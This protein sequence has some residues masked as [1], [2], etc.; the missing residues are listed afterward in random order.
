MLVP[1]AVGVY[2]PPITRKIG[3]NNSFEVKEQCPVVAITI[4]GPSS[5]RKKPAGEL[6]GAGVLHA[7]GSPYAAQASFED[8]L[9]QHQEDQRK[10]KIGH[11]I[12]AIDISDS[13]G[14]PSGLP[15]GSSKL[16]HI[17]AT[18]KILHEYGIPADT[19]LTLI[20]YDE[21]TD[22]PVQYE[23]DLG[24]FFQAIKNL[25]KRGSTNIFQALEVAKMRFIYHE[26]NT[27]DPDRKFFMLVTDGQ[28]NSGGKNSLDIYDEADHLANL[29]CGVFS[30]GVGEL[31]EESLIHGVAS[32]A[33][34]GG[35]CHTPEDKSGANVFAL[36]IPAFL[37]QMQTMDFYLKILASGFSGDQGNIR[38]F[39][40]NNNVKRAIYR[41]SDKH[42]N[43][44]H[45]LVREGYLREGYSIGFAPL[46]AI[47]SGR[48]KL[49]LS[50]QKNVNGDL[51]FPIKDIDIIPIEDL[52][53]RGLFEAGEEAKR[54]LRQIQNAPLVWERFLCEHLR[55]PNAFH[56]FNERNPGFVDPNESVIVERN[57]RDSQ[58][59]RGDESLS[60]SS[61]SNIGTR[62]TNDT[63]CDFRPERAGTVS[64]ADHGRPRKPPQRGA[65]DGHSGPLHTNLDASEGG[66][67][68]SKKPTP[69]D[70]VDLSQVQS[71]G[72]QSFNPMHSGVFLGPLSANPID[73]DSHNNVPP[74]KAPNPTGYGEAVPLFGNASIDGSIDVPGAKNLG[75]IAY[76]SDGKF[77]IEIL[78]GGKKINIPQGALDKANITLG[79][80]PD[81]EIVIGV[82]AISRVH[83]TINRSMI[84]LSIIDRGST[85]GTYVNGERVTGERILQNGDIVK[86]TD[87]QFRVY[88]K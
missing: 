20:A 15:D 49:Q 69:P 51:V 80:S 13:M 31:Y 12:F 30:V 44:R 88:I 75:E 36:N 3:I 42:L 64:D 2:F 56:D 86:I 85:N 14:A 59:G 38:F 22:M 63:I 81:C 41:T 39:D 8:D 25:K 11:I 34:Y 74:F 53:S 52:P 87:V 43:T 83:C 27:K 72:D 37:D 40:L 26:T 79:R 5:V 35:W 82:S 65:Y 58:Q 76:S 61:V 78:R 66:K 46:D 47:K 54:I 33:G 7:G 50:V 57:M 71:G 55:D 32:H 29:N 68:P 18:I 10:Y 48:A 17:I 21:K 4:Q 16:D 6:V 73:V 70:G 60:R 1:D 19:P 24:I 67:D 28:H 23:T 45:Y 77:G 9:D 62:F 84:K